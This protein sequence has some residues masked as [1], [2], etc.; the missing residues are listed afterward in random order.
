MT[1]RDD[2][3]RET[4]TGSDDRRRLVNIILDQ[5]SLAR[6]LPDIEHE[7]KV[8]IFDL[9]E[10]N[11]FAPVGNSDGP[12]TLMLAII[13]SRLMF[14]VHDHNE[15]QCTT[16]LLSLTPFRR[17]VRD[18]FLICESYFEAIKTAPPKPD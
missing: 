9:L 12:Y 17:I 1:E 18:Y 11:Q 8:A 16:V 2:T 4:E 14:D 10:E 5:T 15:V 3:T 13:E 7:R 6:A